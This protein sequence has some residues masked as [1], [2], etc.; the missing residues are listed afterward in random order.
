MLS[1][2]GGFRLG[3]G[4]YDLS[5]KVGPWRTTANDLRDLEDRINEISDEVD[6]IRAALS[7]STPPPP[8]SS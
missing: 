4:G 7:A 6:Q 3:H 8:P 1:L 5:K 2:Y